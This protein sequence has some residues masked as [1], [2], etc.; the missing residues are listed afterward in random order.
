MKLLPRETDILGTHNDWVISQNEKFQELISDLRSKK[1]ESGK[2]ERPWEFEIVPGFFK[3]SDP[4]TNDADFSYIEDDFGLDC[5][6]W[7]DLAAHLE[8]LNENAKENESYKLLFCARHGEGYHNYAL[9]KYGRE[10]WINHWSR[11]GTDGEMV[12]GPDPFLTEL[13]E[14]QADVNRD[15]WLKNLEKGTPMPTKFYSSPF[16]RSAMTLVRT[17]DGICIEGDIASGSGGALLKEK[18]TPVIVEDLRETIGK[19]LCDKRSNK[20][21]IEERLDKYGFVFEPNFLFED[22]FYK[23]DYRESYCEQAVRADNFLQSVF[24]NDKDHQIISVTSHSGTI[25]ALLM[26]TKHRRFAI[27]TGGMIPIVVK[28]TRKDD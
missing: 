6:S 9:Q 3:Q 14:K 5:E 18:M 4:N 17:W 8:K 15:A 2:F 23:D 22:E 26:A 7:G 21:I 28:A 13:G 27:S 12:W 11:L 10:D 24:E 1:N 19:H 20:Q 16:T 25:R